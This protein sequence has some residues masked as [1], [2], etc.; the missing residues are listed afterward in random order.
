MSGN[1]VPLFRKYCG[2]QLILYPPSK[3]F[4]SAVYCLAWTRANNSLCRVV[5]AEWK[6]TNKAAIYDEIFGPNIWTRSYVFVG[7]IIKKAWTN[8]MGVP[9][10][11]TNI[12]CCAAVLASSPR[13]R[14]QSPVPQYLNEPF[15]NN[16]DSGNLCFATNQSFTCQ[17]C[18]LLACFID[19]HLD[20][21]C[22]SS[23]EGLSL[24]HLV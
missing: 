5:F 23:C 7:Q 24:A 15:R 16:S 13:R 6:N 3:I 8:P 22:I 12:V 10:L 18:F 4:C 20:L 2:F 21:P 9:K 14:T 19:L 1:N 11:I 17:H